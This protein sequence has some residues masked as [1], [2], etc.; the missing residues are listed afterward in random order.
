[1]R[2]LSLDCED[3]VAKPT[4]EWKASLRVSKEDA[5]LRMPMLLVVLF[6]CSLGSFGP[7]Q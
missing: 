2:A 5:E 3:A 1:M 4:K 7:A 6:V